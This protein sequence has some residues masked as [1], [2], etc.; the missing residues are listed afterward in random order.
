MKRKLSISIDVSLP[1][2]RKIEEELLWLVIELRQWIIIILKKARAKH[3][4]EIFSVTAVVLL[5]Y[6][7]YHAIHT[8]L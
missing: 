4:K 6:C 7:I 1:V 5:R 2:A 3:K 8:T